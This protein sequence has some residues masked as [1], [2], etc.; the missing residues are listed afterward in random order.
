MSSFL[1][2]LITLT[3][4]SPLVVFGAD[5]ELPARTASETLT[6]LTGASPARAVSDL[7]NFALGIGAIA[8]FGLIV[9]SA[10]QYT[11]TDSPGKRQEAQ[12]RIFQSLL[13]LLLLIGATLVLRFINPDLPNLKNPEAPQLEA[14]QL[15]TTSESY[16]VLQKCP[17]LLQDCSNDLSYALASD[18]GEYS[19]RVLC[20]EAGSSTIGGTEPGWWRCVE[21]TRD[22]SGLGGTAGP[23]CEP[24]PNPGVGS[25]QYIEEKLAGTPYAG[26]FG[27][28]IAKASG[29][30]GIE[31]GG[32]ETIE[33]RTDKCNPAPPRSVSIGLFQINL[34]AHHLGSLQCAN[35]AIRGQLRTSPNDCTI[36]DEVQYGL[37]LAEAKKATPNIIEAC[38][39][40]R[41]KN[42]SFQLWGPQTKEKCGI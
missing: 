29:I 16:W 27:D 10:L 2:I 33:S 9:Y 40:F 8:A 26:C 7:Y 15:D 1:T 3:F 37:C 36:I 4:L 6:L 34:S 11:T 18:R 5:Y 22:T 31:S 25:V 23:G 24:I 17:A 39:T 35:K 12:G 28:K 21:R 20:A 19:S 42:N 41:M 38:K 13:G 30:I 14:I 32:Q